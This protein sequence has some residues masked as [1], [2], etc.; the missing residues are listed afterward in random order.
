M[1]NNTLK[2]RLTEGKKVSLV[3]DYLKNGSEMKV[4]GRTYVWLDNYVVR[5][6]VQEDGTVESFGIDG[7]A[8]KALSY[9]TATG[10]TT[11]HYIGQQDMTLVDFLQLVDELEEEDWVGI[12]AS[13]ALHK[14]IPDRS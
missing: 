6:E 4:G 3:L 1:E 11:P 10:E 7:L 5:E 13:N 14:M 2:S 12:T 8:L 9:D